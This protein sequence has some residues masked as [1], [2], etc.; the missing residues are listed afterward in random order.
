M[1]YSKASNEQLEAKLVTHADNKYIV[2]AVKRE[3]RSRN[4]VA[5]V[6]VEGD[7]NG[8]GVFDKKDR[9]IAGKVLAKGRK[10]NKK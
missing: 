10:K 8:D 9:S 7:L 2:R 6:A 1:T 3:I 4:K 5:P